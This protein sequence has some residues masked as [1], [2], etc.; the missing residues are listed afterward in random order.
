MTKATASRLILVLSTTEAARPLL[1]ALHSCLKTV[2][3]HS[4]AS[5]RVDIGEMVLNVSQKVVQLTMDGAMKM[6]LAVKM[7]MAASIVNVTLLPGLLVTV[8]VT[9]VALLIHV[10]WVTATKMP[11]V[12]STRIIQCSGIVSLDSLVMAKHAL[13]SAL[14]IMVAALLMPSA[15][16]SKVVTNALAPMAMRVMVLH[17]SAPKVK[18]RSRMRPDSLAV[19]MLIPTLFVAITNHGLGSSGH[20]FAQADSN[21]LLAPMSP[22]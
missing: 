6:L 2:A 21:H 22:T 1:I 16:P 4:S 10:Y 15:L 5:A 20:V 14:K 13:T 19:T 18:A 11:H 7:M 9:M 17:V 12:V 8:T 3:L